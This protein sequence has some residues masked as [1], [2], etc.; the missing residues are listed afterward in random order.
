[1]GKRFFVMILM[2]LILVGGGLMILAAIALPDTAHL[3]PAVTEAV[4]RA[5]GQTMTFAEPAEFSFSPLPKVTLRQVVLGGGANR[6]PLFRA[7]RVELYPSLVSL[8]LH[9]MTYARVGLDQP[10]VTLDRD[11]AGHWVLPAGAGQ[12]GLAGGIAIRPD[13]I[14][15]T[16]GVL[17]IRDAVAG[18]RQAA[19]PSLN[20]T[21]GAGLMFPP[22]EAGGPWPVALT[23][24]GDQTAL[25]ITGTVGQPRDGTGIAL[26][27]DGT[28]HE[29]LLLTPLFPAMAPR[30]PHDI[31]VHAEVID[32]PH[33]WAALRA[34]DLKIKVID[35]GGGLRLDDVSVS[36]HDAVPA[37][38]TATLFHPGL[39]I[40]ITG[41]AGDLAW[42]NGAG[43]GPLTLDLAWK[44]PLASGTVKG[45]PGT[46]LD[47]TA[48]IPDPAALLASAPPGFKGLTIKAHVTSLDAPLH[49]SLTAAAGDAD[50]TLSL[51]LSDSGSTGLAA[52]RMLLSGP[53]RIRADGSSTHF[54]LDTF[55][56]PRGTPPADRVDGAPGGPVGP[57]PSQLDYLTKD[58]PFD[59]PRSAEGTLGFQVGTLRVHGRELKNV[60]G[61]MTLADGVL[62]IRPLYNQVPRING[63]AAAAPAIIRTPPPMVTAPGKAAIP[64]VIGPNGRLQ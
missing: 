59:L 19:I 3:G 6:D 18:T 34:L 51:G 22:I 5:T 11:A 62:H 17:T 27:L 44:A 14:Q 40:A 48:A 28:L 57:A 49:V 53:P 1:M 42:V 15:I 20:I 50:G 8:L 43:A 37:R 26:K 36:A 30:L 58:L 52:A 24:H 13:E 41:T 39:P 35:L 9:R 25:T 38:V 64:T 23:L 12:P 46:G 21:A 33:G 47:L 55:F 61:T 56:G 54:D 32:G 4:A 63:T 45:T 29:P 16:G 2:G 7:D 31:A 60:A 10:R